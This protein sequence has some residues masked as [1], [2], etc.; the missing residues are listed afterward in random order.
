MQVQINHRDLSSNVGLEQV[1]GLGLPLL[2][3][4][5]ANRDFWH[6]VLGRMALIIL[7]VW[8]MP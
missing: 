4:T 5:L 1:P 7:L 6:A 3:L 8:V 2:A